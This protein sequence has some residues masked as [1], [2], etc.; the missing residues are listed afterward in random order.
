M[1]CLARA[2]LILPLSAPYDK[3][4]GTLSRGVRKLYIGGRQVSVARLVW[5][6]HHGDYPDGRVFYRDG[7]QSNTRI[8][9][10]RLGYQKEGE[11]PE[12]ALERELTQTRAK[13]A[14]AERHVN[15][16]LLKELNEYHFR[17]NRACEL[18][19]CEDKERIE[20]ELERMYA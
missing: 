1:R 13:L 18:L 14:I 8:E 12:Y 11:S 20:L 5:A 3:P 7:D 2:L 19:D 6:D 15:T 10:L 16:D 9:N 17:W 4:A